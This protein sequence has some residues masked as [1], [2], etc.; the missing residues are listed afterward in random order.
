MHASPTSNQ[1]QGRKTIGIVTFLVC[2]LLSSARLVHDA[3]NP[4]TP[5]GDIAR[6]SDQRFSALKAAL[7]E[8][9]VV[10]YIGERGIP[11]LGDY[12]LAQYALAP[13][14]IDHSTNHALVVGNFSPQSSPGTLPPGLHLIREFGGGVFLYS[15]NP[16][17]EEDRR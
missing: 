13:L 6:R 3:P 5:P 17:A 10:G 14:V 16:F 2:C 15:N 1:L 9:G 12:Y 11:A 4:R 7:P 8:R